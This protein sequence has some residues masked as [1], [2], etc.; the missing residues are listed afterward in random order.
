MENNCDIKSSLL[1]NSKL[2]FEFL[3]KAI[4]ITNYLQNCHPTKT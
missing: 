4:D 3:A 2:I 1:I